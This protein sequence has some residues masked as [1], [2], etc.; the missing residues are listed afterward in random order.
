MRPKPQVE[1]CGIYSGRGEKGRG[2]NVRERANVPT[3]IQQAS[4]EREALAAIHHEPLGR[5]T[6]NDQ[7]GVLGRI[8]AAR[9]LG[10]NISRDI[11]RQACADLVRPA[12]QLAL[13]EIRLDERYVRRVSEPTRKVTEEVRIN[14]VG[15]DMSAALGQWLG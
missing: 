9:Q 11:E 10:D 12:R 14:L 2:R 8:K 4:D 13:Q 7:V 15:H 6:L 3:W 5:F 1:Q